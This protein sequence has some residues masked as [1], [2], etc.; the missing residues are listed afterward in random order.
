MCKNVMIYE[1][2]MLNVTVKNPLDNVKCY[3]KVAKVA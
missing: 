2:S 1:L 3:K